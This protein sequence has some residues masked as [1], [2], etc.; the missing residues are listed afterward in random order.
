M[1]GVR[2]IERSWLARVARRNLRVKRV[3]MVLGGTIH[4]SGATREEFLQSDAWVAHELAHLEQ[5]RR[6]GIVRFVMLYLL[7]SARHGYHH[8]R[9]EVAARQAERV[10]SSAKER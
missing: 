6:Y 10:A 9:F 4:L 2:I 1:N 3:A 8:N 5:F 7:E